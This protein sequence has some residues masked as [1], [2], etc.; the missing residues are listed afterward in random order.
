MQAEEIA[1]PGLQHPSHTVCPSS[2]DPFYL[3]SYYVKWVTTS[4]TYGR[5]ITF[6][7]SSLMWS[8]G[9]NSTHFHTNVL[10]LRRSERQAWWGWRERPR[11]EHLE[12]NYPGR[13]ETND[14]DVIY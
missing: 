11:N 6:S 8:L 13:Q 10:G 3:V 7:A 1:G 14:A 4:W 5:N 9:M 2:S 12:L